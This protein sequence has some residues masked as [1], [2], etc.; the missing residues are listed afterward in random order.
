MV[1]A[2]SLEFKGPQFEILK[3]GR[4]FRN[5]YTWQW[6]K[7]RFT[8]TMIPSG[9]VGILVRRYGE[10]LPKGEVVAR[11]DKQ[12]GIVLEPLMPGRHYIN[13][14]A[15]D[16]EKVNMVKI[17]PGHRGVVTLRVGKI[18]K[19]PFGFTVERGEQGTQ[20]DLLPPGTH[21]QHS[22]PYVHLVTSI[23]IRSHKLD[24]SGE[25]SIWF[26]SKY[27]FEIQVDG[28]IEW[29]PDL[30]K[31][32]EVFVKFV[33]AKDLARSGGIT[34]I[35]Q[36]VILPYAR[37]FFRTIGGS[38]RAV[39]YITGDTRVVV[40]SMVED[41]LKQAC[42]A[43]GITIRSVVIKATTP[44][45][46]IRQ[47]YE[48]REI[49]LRL[50]DRYEKEIEMEIGSVVMVGQTPKLDK[51]GKPMLNSMGKPVMVGGKA[52]IGSDGKPVRAGGRL[53]QVIF[54]R[55]KDRE[56]KLGAL[57]QEVV[58]VIREAEQYSVV[59]V[60]K[61]QK[62]FE[63]AKIKLEAAKDRAAATLAKGT[64]E[65][66]V[67]VMEYKAEAEGVKAKITA[68]ETGEK[69]AEY[70]LISRLAP[71]ITEVLSNTEGLFAKLFERFITLTKE[72]PKKAAGAGR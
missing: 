27:G 25:N 60:T 6:P 51:N 34:N 32:P 31:L 8:A 45:P 3:E 35:E 61:A 52:K 24:M 65:A 26:P 56:E 14:W 12:K 2:P 48:R 33:D 70:A 11:T 55:K 69:Y 22:N 63:V 16:V 44:P 72:A 20:P 13:T 42:S 58:R 15:Y 39:D 49:A 19:D 62:E 17:E 50:K 30:E 10:A 57:R 68:F 47:Q 38:Y 7:Q 43:E 71:G 64:A 28:I 5:P 66:A 23:D 1:L 36:K 21:P 29:A 67:T 54:K 59:E 46:K 9:K 4:H 37:S 41:R 40:Q 53:K 18:P